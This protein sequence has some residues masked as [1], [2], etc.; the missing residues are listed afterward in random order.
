[1]LPVIWTKPMSCRRMEVVVERRR[2]N[3]SLLPA[4]CSPQFNTGEIYV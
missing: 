1:L 2:L 3:S 4:S